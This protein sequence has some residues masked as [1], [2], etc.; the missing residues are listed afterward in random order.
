MQ[1][2]YENAFKEIKKDNVIIHGSYSLGEVEALKV[3]DV[4]LILSI[5]PETY[6]ISLSEAWQN[7]LIPIVTDVG[8]LG[9]RVDDG[10]NG[11]KVEI[12]SVN[13]VIDR[14]ELIR[15][16]ER[17]RSLI[18]SNIGPKLWI[19][20]VDYAKQLYDVYVRIAPKK[21][22]G[23]SDLKWDVGR[24]GFIPHAFWKEQ[25]PPRHILDASNES[26]LSIELP[27]PVDNWSAIQGANYYIDDICYHVLNAKNEVK[28]LPKDEFHIR[29][30]FTFESF[31]NAGTLLVALIAQDSDLI[32]FLD[33]Q[34]E[35]REDVASSF[36]NAP[37]RNGFSG[38]TALRG[39]WCEGT[40]RIGLV[41]IVNGSA[42]FQ[43]T[44]YEIKVAGGKITKVYN[45]FHSNQ[46]ILD[47]FN[48]LTRKDGLIRSIK[49]NNLF[50]KNIHDQ[51]YG[52]LEYCIEKLSGF[53][54]GNETPSEEVAGTK[55]IINISGW[56]YNR[57]NHL[58]GHMYVAFVREDMN[59][60][61][62]AATYRYVRKQT[63]E[64]FKNAPL[65]N[66]FEVSL[67]L[68]KGLYKK[69]K[70]NYYLVLVN[71]IRKEYKIVGVNIVFNIQD[72]LVKE[73][74]DCNL[75][76]ELFL[77]IEQMVEKKLKH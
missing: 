38:Q 4:A 52:E 65:N 56:A 60:C 71:I 59:D 46:T 5:W 47:D 58:A 43:L 1:P 18:M 10:V 27:V 40:F 29:G 70:G 75:T 50:D 16:D 6:C 3:A 21:K 14:L 53:I 25:A 36:T 33:C 12:G 49:L 62:F 9:D 24:L 34:R 63:E 19:E 30:W 77:Q 42:A 26:R 51:Y 28:F 61:F 13:T 41:N 20:A 31:S 64:I 76:A 22:F 35:N 69:I 44:Q 11:F 39:K 48:R 8:G 74:N 66:G 57:N 2:D 45:T 37:I 54:S 7:G 73:I 55:S 68:N 72:N 67:D 17:L 23:W 32:I 15:A